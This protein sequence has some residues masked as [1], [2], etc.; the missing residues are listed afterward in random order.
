MRELKTIEIDFDVHKK[1]E[2]ARMSFADTPNDVLRRLLGLVPQK[3]TDSKQPAESSMRDSG[4]MQL[5]GIF[6]PAGTEL[7]KRYKGILHS[8]HVESGSI[9]LNGKRF[10]SPSMAGIEVTGYN[11]NG[12]RF[13]EGRLPGSSQWR[14]LE[15]IRHR[16]G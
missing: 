12:Y 3:S 5:D 10:Q 14:L 1:I 11:V 6:L 9:V 16:A 7:R 13:W 8:A 15:R 4:G 2:E